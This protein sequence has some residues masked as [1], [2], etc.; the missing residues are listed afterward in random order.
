MAAAV[1]PI[2]AG[3]VPLAGAA[4]EIQA[5]PLDAVHAHPAGVLSDT[6]D[7]PPEAGNESASVS[8]TRFFGERRGG[9]QSAS[10]ISG[11]PTVT[12]AAAGPARETVM[13]ARVTPW[14]ETL[15]SAAWRRHSG[16][17]PNLRCRSAPAPGSGAGDKGHGGAWRQRK[18]AEYAYMAELFVRAGAHCVIPDFVGVEH[19]NGDLMTIVP[20]DDQADPKVA[21]VAAK[22][23]IAAGLD[24]VVG[25]YN[26]GAGLVT[27]P[28]YID[29]G[30]VPL[31][32]T[33]SDQTSGWVLMP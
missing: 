33:S 4:T 15:A 24:A 2:A 31:R 32:L 8:S 13:A 26:S 21:K 28:L 10:T 23:A 14:T 18:A 17:P 1:I 6:D 9:T 5:A 3:P 12:N 29:A 30:L 16:Q 22:R 19:C 20:I 27:L 11:M 25:P 7:V